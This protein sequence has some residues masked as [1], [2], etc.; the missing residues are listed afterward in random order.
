[1]FIYKADLFCFLLLSSSQM[2]I[3]NLIPLPSLSVCTDSYSAAGSEGSIST[4]VASLPPQ[5]S[6]SSAP[7]S[8]GSRRS[9]ST[10]KKWLTNPVRKLSAGAAG[11]AK[12]ER[13]VRKLDGKP[14]SPP[15]RSSQ[16]L[17]SP[18]TTE[19]QFTIL[20]VID[21]ELV[22]KMLLCGMFSLKS[23][24]IFHYQYQEAFILC[25]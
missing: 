16:D 6:G 23:L 12:G 11:T 14:P 10:L 9:V 21:K 4:S 13:Q 18:Q 25:F 7:N 2:V 17:G 15:T 24:D 3:P 22:R 1:M 20:P 5:A 8:P 19:E